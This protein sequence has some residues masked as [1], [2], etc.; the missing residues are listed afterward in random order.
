MK[1]NL[2][3]LAILTVLLGCDKATSSGTVKK[4]GHAANADQNGFLKGADL[5]ESTGATQ[6]TTRVNGRT[7]QKSTPGSSCLSLR[8]LTKLLRVDAPDEPIVINTYDVALGSGFSRS[9]TFQSSNRPDAEGN[10][11]F[12]GSDK[13]SLVF[14]AGHVAELLGQNTKPLDPKDPTTFFNFTG[15]DLCKSATLPDKSVVSFDQIDANSLQFPLDLITYQYQVSKNSIR[16]SVFRKTSGPAAC[17]YGGN[18]IKT[19]Y[20]FSFKNDVQTVRVGSNL[21]KLMTSYISGVKDQL[22]GLPRGVIPAA[23][24]WIATKD[25]AANKVPPVKCAEPK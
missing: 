3:F 17:G 11:L 6:Q 1:K 23:S 9:N 13:V 16:V 24:Y 15:Q 22:K 10:T 20:L 2:I 19:T 8:K 14:S 21:Y 7:V 5:T 4:G 12:M 25:L 18:L